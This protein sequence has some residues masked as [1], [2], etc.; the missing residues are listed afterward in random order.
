[1]ETI[2]ETGR[3]WKGDICDPMEANDLGESFGTE[4][5][6][7]QS[8]RHSKGSASP[9]ATIRQLEGTDAILDLDALESGFF[10]PLKQQYKMESVRGYQES[11]WSRSRSK[12]SVSH[13]STIRQLEG[14]RRHS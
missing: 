6:E 9:S 11:R 4:D 8:R 1:M 13:T 3:L 2:F 10:D 5:K 12:G 14:A 7:R